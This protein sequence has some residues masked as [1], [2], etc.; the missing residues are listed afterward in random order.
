MAIRQPIYAVMQR[1]FSEVQRRVRVILWTGAIL[2]ILN[3]TGSGQE[4]HPTFV[5]PR[6]HGP[7][8]LNGRIDEPAWAE[9][10]PLPLAIHLPT[11]GKEPSERTEIRI[12]YDDEN[13][14]VAARF[15]DSNP[16]GVQGNA[17]TR[18]KWSASDD[19]LALI[20]DTFNDNENGV[21]FITTPSGKRVDFTIVND[22][23][24]RGI[25][26][27]DDS[28]NTFWDVA[29]LRN[30]EG[31]FAEMRIPFSSLRYQVNDGKVVM[32]LIV[33]RW[34]ARKA[35]FD[36]YPPIPPNW[37]DAYIKP[38]VAADVEFDGIGQR[39]PVYVTPYGLGGLNRTFRLNGA[40]N[41]FD[42]LEHQNLDAGADLKY[43][44][45][46]NLNLDL[47]VN[48][49]FA[50]VEADDQQINL[51]R[52]SLFFPEKRQFFL[53]QA[54]IFDFNT[55]DNTRLFYSR[56][57]GLSEEGSPTRIFGGGRLAG[58][59]GEWDVGIL[60]MQTEASGSQPGENAGVLRLRRHVLD[61]YS[62]L[63]GMVTSRVGTDRS[64]NL[65]Y[66]VDGMFHLPGQDFLY[67]NW[68]QTFDGTHDSHG[69][70]NERIRLLWERNVNVGVGYSLGVTSS[71][72][73]YNPG[74]GF[75]SR[76]DFTD[77]LNHISWGWI[78]T[79]GS[80]L[81]AERVSLDGLLGTRN[82]DGKVDHAGLGLTW[83]GDSK[84]GMFYQATVRS[85]YEE[86]LSTFDLSEEAFVPPGKYTTLF[87][88]ASARLWGKLFRGSVSMHAGSYYDGSQITLD[89]APQWSVSPHLQVSGE[90][91]LTL[92]R[93]PDRGQS[94]PANI[95]R[96]RANVSFDIHFSITSFVQW[97]SAS[98]LT[99]VNGR[100]RYNFAEGNDLYVVYSENLNNDRTRVEPVL[101][102]SSARS[103][104]VKY[105]YT[106]VL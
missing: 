78:P 106:F 24:D 102:L 70:D 86:L 20:L 26:P 97:N 80:S 3:S 66:G 45:G 4:R 42:R 27:V 93:F 40:H 31:W 34:I 7:I 61:E 94:F 103:I 59:W 43:S 55:G 51:T 83:N 41:G 88:D 56:R 101:P 96:A 48:T 104:A 92:I 52:F 32:G 19:Q 49:D 60:D 77:I 28:W 1:S 95:L 39:S 54:S 71:A 90:Y 22:N 98:H 87:M 73:R 76:T 82:V 9:V 18:D 6:I 64:Y 63:G 68:A 75:T 33:W 14:Y 29:T 81:Q 65:A 46:S 53:E 58:R 15:Y 5:V 10:D 72:A 105:T 84:D 74:L 91:Q 36:T 12:G 69:L 13:L 23:V 30:D 17:L 44:P 100:A 8:E 25:D 2:G 21:A 38:S 11:F 37:V 50:Q 99:I 79:D 85:E 16:A 47:T 62:T 89:I 35:E 57:I 67:V